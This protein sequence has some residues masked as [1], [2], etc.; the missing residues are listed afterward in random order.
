M[1]QSNEILLRWPFCNLQ[2]PVVIAVTLLTPISGN[3]AI[4]QLTN[5]WEITEI[6]RDSAGYLTDVLSVGDA[7]QVD[8]S[9]DTSKATLVY[10]P[11]GNPSYAFPGDGAQIT[12]TVN[13]FSWATVDG[14]TFGAYNAPDYDVVYWSAQTTEN[15]AGRPLTTISSPFD[16]GAIDKKMWQSLRFESGTVTGNDL[17]E[18]LSESQVL[19]YP[20]H[21]MGAVEET[22]RDIYGNNKGGYLF[23]FGVPVPVTN[24]VPVPSAVWLFGSGLIGLIG[25][26]RR[27]KA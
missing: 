14:L 27:K 26:A 23:R 21:Y 16:I 7:I 11:A 25:F 5:T 2:V 22:I 17:P 4:I 9:Y 24:E 18:M 12:Y 3:C 1:F 13:G 20:N 10:T 19:P 8:A 15:I 6:S